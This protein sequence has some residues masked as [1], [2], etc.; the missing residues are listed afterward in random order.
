MKALAKL[1][2]REKQVILL[3]LVEN[4][5]MHVVAKELGIA[6]RT[7]VNTKTNA[8]RRLVASMQEVL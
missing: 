1:T 5:N 2:P 6:Y 4:K 8:L 7:V 3:N